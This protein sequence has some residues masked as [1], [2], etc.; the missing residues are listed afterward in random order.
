[1]T[2]KSTE[3]IRATDFQ[4]GT[5]ART[6]NF[7]IVTGAQPEKQRLQ[8]NGIAITHRTR[9]GNIHSPP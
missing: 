1:M 8:L 4:D 7:C 2:P 3:T 9:K 5:D 6:V